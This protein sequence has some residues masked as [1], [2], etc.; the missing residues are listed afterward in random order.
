MKRQLSA[1]ELERHRNIVAAELSAVPSLG[2]FYKG[3]YW[4]ATGVILGGIALALWLGT[5]LCLAYAVGA[6]TDAFGV[7]IHWLALLLN[8][9]TICFGLLPALL[10]WAWAAVEAFVEPDLRHG[11]DG[12]SAQRRKRARLPKLP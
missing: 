7:S 4:E 5:L 12:K 2:Q 9:I 10:F 11:P 1:E 3:H 8:P 6:I